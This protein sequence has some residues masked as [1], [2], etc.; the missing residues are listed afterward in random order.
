[1]LNSELVGVEAADKTNNSTQLIHQKSE[2]MGIYIQVFW[3]MLWNPSYVSYTL[4]IENL[5]KDGGMLLGDYMLQWDWNV[6]K[7]I[8]FFGILNENAD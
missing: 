3:M 2:P 8:G 5:D 7:S 4:L 6:S 1:M